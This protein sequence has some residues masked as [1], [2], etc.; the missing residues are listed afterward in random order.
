MRWG[1]LGEV[2]NGFPRPQDTLPGKHDAAR[3]PIEP[4]SSELSLA[5]VFGRGLRVREAALHGDLVSACAQ[6]HP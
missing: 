1:S 4:C 5:E 2:G 3:A 6:L